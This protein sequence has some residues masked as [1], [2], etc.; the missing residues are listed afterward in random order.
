MFCRRSACRGLIALLV[1]L[2]CIVSFYALE[3]PPLPDV[4]P[5][6]KALQGHVDKFK[7]LRDDLKALQNSQDRQNPLAFFRE[8][9][10]IMEGLQSLG[11]D[12]KDI[13]RLQNKNDRDR[14]FENLLTEMDP[15]CGQRT[16]RTAFFEIKLRCSYTD[17]GGKPY[18][19]IGP[20]KQ[21][22]VNR[23]P[24]V[25]TVYHDLLTESE[26]RR[27]NETRMIEPSV[28]RRLDT[29]VPNLYNVAV[30]EV[31][32]RGYNGGKVKAPAHSIMLYLESYKT[33][34]MTLFPGGTFV[35]APRSGSLLVSKQ[36]P[37]ICPSSISLNVITNFNLPLTAK[38]H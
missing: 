20:L 10:R 38:T 33:G 21:E 26:V 8:T 7:K 37:S 25:V 36:H 3:A 12:W 30:R 34:G 6:A 29:L 17:L 16:P 14:D 27:A 9:M 22:L 28:R 1:L 19:R 5:L 13:E 31:S 23:V 18:Y 24:F 4:V 2:G 35:V 11:K 15:L 32:E